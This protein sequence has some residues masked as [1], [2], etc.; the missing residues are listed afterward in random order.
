VVPGAAP[1]QALLDG[2]PVAVSSG[3]STEFGTIDL[4]PGS[5]VVEV[6]PDMSS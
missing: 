6:V 4:P 3:S 2:E 1:G 5:H